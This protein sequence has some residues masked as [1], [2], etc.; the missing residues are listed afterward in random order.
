MASCIR[1]L[2]IWKSTLSTIVITLGIWSIWGADV[3][4]TDGEINRG[5]LA[6]VSALLGGTMFCISLLPGGPRRITLPIQFRD[7]S[8]GSITLSSEDVS[9]I[10]GLRRVCQ[11]NRNMLGLYADLSSNVFTAGF[12]WIMARNWILSSPGA[13][14]STFA[15]LSIA[16]A[17][18]SAIAV[19]IAAIRPYRGEIRP[20]QSYIESILEQ[21][22]ISEQHPP[23]SPPDQD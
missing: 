13:G 14:P 6:S 10:A 21:H 8:G 15:D 9:D 23:K 1:S 3:T 4:R 17:I 7:F 2:L 19:S 16:L 11:Q 5:L 20:S 18:I 22:R 12:T